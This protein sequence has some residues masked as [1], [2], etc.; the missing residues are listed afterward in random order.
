M[1]RSAVRAVALGVAASLLVALAASAQ[2]ASPTAGAIVVDPADCTVAPRSFADV[3]AVVA[4][5]ISTSLEATAAASGT[6]LAGDQRS[7]IPPAG[8]VADPATVSAATGTIRQ[9]Y[10]CLAAKNAGAVAAF[11]T[12]DFIRLYLF[13][14]VGPFAPTIAETPPTG[15][16]PSD[17]AATALPTAARGDR[18]VV[19][20]VQTLPDGR[21]G[22]LVD[23]MSDSGTREDYVLL[24]ER[25]GHYLIE[26]LRAGVDGN[27]TGELTPTP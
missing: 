11:V 13:A 19:R 24:S 12:D 23:L 1:S 16:P 14:G 15:T 3:Q 22:A 6:L 25:N 10:S 9:F 17:T 4:T 20:D 18:L 26:A 21:V 2:N 27:P 5:P 7:F 8:Q